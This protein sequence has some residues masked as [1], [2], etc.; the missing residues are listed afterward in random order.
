METF[1]NP[2]TDRHSIG[3]RPQA[4][5]NEAGNMR[6]VLSPHSLHDLMKKAIYILIVSNERIQAISYAA[7]CG[8]SQPFALPHN[9]P[10]SS[11]I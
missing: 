10:T 3:G 9:F 2:S 1:T 11:F 7:D 6:D 4:G 8:L 5:H